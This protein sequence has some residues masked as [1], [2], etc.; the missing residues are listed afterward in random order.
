MKHKGKYIPTGAYGGNFKSWICLATLLFTGTVFLSGQ[1]NSQTLDD[2]IRSADDYFSKSGQLNNGARI[3]VLNVQSG[4]KSLSDYVVNELTR[5][6]VNGKK[7]TVVER[8]DLSQL[9]AEQDFQVS[10]MVSDETIQGIGRLWG[11]QLIISG[12][13]KP[14]GDRYRLDFK[15]LE[16]ET[17]R[18]AAQTAFDVYPDSRLNSLVSGTG[19]KKITRFSAWL[20]GDDSWKHKWFYPGH[21]GG[22]LS[23]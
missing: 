9:Q 14:L 17:G 22:R 7:F 5:H 15:A 3:A 21:T 18:I 20:N 8:G 12:S 2:A 10:G 23:P 6:I 4:W 16:V 11:A 13:F 19:A 1:Q